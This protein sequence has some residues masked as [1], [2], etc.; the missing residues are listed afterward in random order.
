[1][2]LAA[3]LGCFSFARGADSRSATVT[4]LTR[5]HAH[6]DYEHKRPLFDALDNG[7]CSI[8]ADIFVVGGQLLVAHTRE[9]VQPDRTLTALYLDPLQARIKQN[10]GRVYSGG[11]SVTLLIDIKTDA[12]ATYAVL[13]PLLEKYRDMLTEFRVDRMEPRAITV[14]LSGNMPRKT[15][16]SETVRLAS[17][18]GR[19]PD[20]DINP[21]V[22]LIPWIS[23]SWPAHFKWRGKGP[24]PPE[25]SARLKKIVAQTHQ[26]GRRLRFWGAPDTPEVWQVFYDAGV[27]LLNAD[28]LPGLRAFVNKAG[29]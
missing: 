26:Q 1:M 8:E 15:V 20:L 13:R 11:P 24:L 9:A 5:V 23:D 21:P 4:P 16:E 22:S 17:C 7:F 27:D 10:G 2:A 14:V 25:E 12:E 3:L 19:L 6:N 29:R 18:D 28:D